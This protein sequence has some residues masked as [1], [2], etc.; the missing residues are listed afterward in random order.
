MK[1]K[2]KPYLIYSVVRGAYI[3]INNIY[4]LEM[5]SVKFSYKK[6]IKKN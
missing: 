1:N 2:C 4:N 3:E 5:E 6:M